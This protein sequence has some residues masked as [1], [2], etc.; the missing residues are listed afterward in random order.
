MAEPL[1]KLQGVSFKYPNTELEENNFAVNNVSFEI[2][3]GE[4]D[5]TVFITPDGV[6]LN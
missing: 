3:R 6:I 2:E 4:W 1:I 5:R